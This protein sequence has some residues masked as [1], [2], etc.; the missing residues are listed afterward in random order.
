MFTTISAS[1]SY[2][3]AVANDT[4]A[5]MSTS[6][7]NRHALAIGLGVGIGVGGFL[8][9]ALAVLYVLKR[10]AKMKRSAEYEKTE[11][12][13]ELDSSWK[14]QLPDSANAPPPT[15]VSHTAPGTGVIHE[16]GDGRMHSTS[17]PQE[18]EASHTYDWEPRNE[19]EPRDGG[20][21]PTEHHT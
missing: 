3:T 7:E 1:S 14:A 20:F 9:I 4:S 6:G 2:I 17:V 18:L 13:S 15:K 5:V 10:R 16:I 21:R 8:V 11:E 12:I 19:P